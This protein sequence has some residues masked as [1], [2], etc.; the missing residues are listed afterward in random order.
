MN[1]PADEPQQKIRFERRA[2]GMRGLVSG[3]SPR[4][5][6]A[7]HMGRNARRVRRELAAASTRC[8]HTFEAL[9]CPPLRYKV[10]M[11]SLISESAKTDVAPA[12]SIKTRQRDPAPCDD[13]Q[14]NSATGWLVPLGRDA[15]GRNAK[16]RRSSASPS[17]S[18]VWLTA[19][20]FRS[21]QP[22]K[23]GLPTCSSVVTGRFKSMP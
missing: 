20:A 11:G 8:C 17:S 13:R 1:C 9:T 22:V 12:L 23:F 4:K 7:P 5:G 18:S 2:A 6:R 16:G 3:G 21:R 10:P 15:K 19:Q 14:A